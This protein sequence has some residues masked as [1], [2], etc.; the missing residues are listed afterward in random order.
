MKTSI[1]AFALL[2]CAFT[3]GFSPAARAGEEFKGNWT[4]MPSSEPGQ[5][6]FGLIHHRDGHH[7]QSESDWPAGEFL[8]LD[9]SDASKR[10]VTFNIARDAGRFD[11]EGYV[12]DG[13]GAGIFRFT[14]D[15][16]YPKAMSALGFDGID[17]EM[18]FA[19]AVHDVSLDFVRAMKAEKVS[20]LT[21]EMLLAFRIH[22][23]TPK[24]I[25]D[26]RAAGLTAD[27]AD[28]LVAFRIHGVTPE[29]V[30]EVRKS[31]LTV[32]EDELIAFRIHG[33]TPAFIAKVETLGYKNLDPDQL[34]A[35]RI[36]GVTPEYIADLKSRGLK[37][38][39]IDQM[40]NLRIHGIN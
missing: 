31:G 2:L 16:Q 17:D 26:I 14:P 4:I 30:R 22:D 28:K 21:T 38:L 8:G 20:G 1:S 32:S 39:T 15:A 7:S 10:D 35:M 24:F 6:R 27:D 13:D 25:R 34:V 33:V 9:L 3:L 37:D 18:Q 19:M 11:C 23:V 36:H 29:M 40:V 5:I 12:K